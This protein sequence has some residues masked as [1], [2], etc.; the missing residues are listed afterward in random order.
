[1]TALELYHEAARRGLRLETRGDKLA[2]IPGDRVP[3]DFAD[4]LRQHRGELL[5]WLE[6]RG[7][8]LTPDEVPWLHVARQILAGE[9]VG[10]LDS[11]VRDSLEIGLRGIVHPLCRRAL[12]RLRATRQQHRRA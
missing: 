1:M 9:F 4:V 12:E 6:A 10:L 11:S 8:N 7:H 3:P 2:V 5:N